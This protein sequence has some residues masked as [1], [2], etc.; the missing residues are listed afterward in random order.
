MGRLG[1]VTGYSDYG[2]TYGVGVSY[3]NNACI[4]TSGG[5][6]ISSQYAKVSANDGSSYGAGAVALSA[7]YIEASVELNIVSD[8][9][10]KHDI[11][12]ELEKYENMY[13]ALLPCSF[14]YDRGTSGREHW[15]L[16]AQDFK[17]A[18][19]DNGLTTE[20]VA[21][22]VEHEDTGNGKCGIRY[23]ELISMNVWQIQ[24]LKARVEA[25]E[26]TIGG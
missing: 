17:C 1:Y 3:G 13:N 15:G 16:I 18:I 4:A 10:V 9:N 20:E 5:A 8:R 12:Y 7:T 11:N 24:K 19:V 2:T 26:Q 14:K 25:L 23:G 21:A 22:Y 6:A